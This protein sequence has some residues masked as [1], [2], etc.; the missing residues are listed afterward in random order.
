MT[1]DVCLSVAYIGPK[2]RTERS[3]TTKNGTEVGHVT[4]DSDTTFKVKRSKVNLQGARRGI[5]W[6]YCG[7]LPHSL[8]LVNCGY[9]QTNLQTFMETSIGRVKTTLQALHLLDRFSRLN[10]KKLGIEE[11]YRQLFLQFGNDIEA[12]KIVR[13]TREQYSILLKKPEAR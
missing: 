6:R 11:K 7:D 10:I 5:L 3:R 4:R 9:L 8:L 2:S 1:S 13:E 12:V